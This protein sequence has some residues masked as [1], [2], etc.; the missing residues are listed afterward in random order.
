MDISEQTIAREIAD[1]L[2]IRDDI[3]QAGVDET[4][5]TLV[6]ITTQGG[7]RYVVYVEAASETTVG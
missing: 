7:K 2:K 3:A 5:D 6:L 1:R 4:D